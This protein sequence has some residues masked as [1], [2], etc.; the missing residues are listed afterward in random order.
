VSKTR[1]R[2]KD[3]N[4]SISLHKGYN[5]GELPPKFAYIYDDNKETFGVNE[6]FNFKGLTWIKE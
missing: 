5:L 1:L 4:G 2:I 3:E 6:W